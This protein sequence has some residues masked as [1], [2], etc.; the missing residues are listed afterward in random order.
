MDL[1][2]PY[3]PGFVGRALY[4]WTKLY[5]GSFGWRGRV[6]IWP[7]IIVGTFLAFAVL[8][9]YLLFFTRAAQLIWF[10][11]FPRSV[12]SNWSGSVLFWRGNFTAIPSAI[13]SSR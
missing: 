12:S 5:Q 1:V 10:A 2:L 7:S 6:A 4:A 8:F 9:V 3:G 11:A 13:A